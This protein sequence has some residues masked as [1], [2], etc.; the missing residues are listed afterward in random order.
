MILDEFARRL[1]AVDAIV[2]AVAGVA[3]VPA[4]AY[5]AIIGLRLVRGPRLATCDLVVPAGPA[6]A[7]ELLLTLVHAVFAQNGPG[8]T[9]LR[10]PIVLG[11][12][13]TA[14]GLRLRLRAEERDMR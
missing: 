9:W 10:T 6:P 2:I 8:L 14:R 13:G 12:R 4:V 11:A 5:L 7:A 1:I 3:L